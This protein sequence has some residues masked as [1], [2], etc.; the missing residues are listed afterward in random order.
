MENLRGTTNGFNTI[1]GFEVQHENDV[2]WLHFSKGTLPVSTGNLDFLQLHVR[3]R[4]LR[5]T[6]GKLLKI[7]P[8]ESHDPII[9]TERTSQSKATDFIR[10]RIMFSL[11]L[12]AV[13]RCFF[14]SLEWP[15]LK[16][17]W[18]LMHLFCNL[19]TNQCR[20]SSQNKGV[21]IY[22]RRPW[23]TTHFTQ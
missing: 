4:F 13:L 10:Y 7:S 23:F 14:M 1:A 22:T 18:K 8:T 19:N 15:I 20:R 17:Y 3:S 16:Q 6:G 21:S 11:C 2:G 5:Q 12:H 9:T